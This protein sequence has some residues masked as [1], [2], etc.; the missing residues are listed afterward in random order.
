MTDSTPATSWNGVDPSAMSKEDIAKIL[1]KIA[2]IEDIKDIPLPVVYAC[3]RR[4][5]TLSVTYAKRIDFLPYCTS[6]RDL[7]LVQ[8]IG[9]DFTPLASCGAL[10]S[11]KITYSTI[12]DITPLASC[13]RL[14]HLDLSRGMYAVNDL[15]P[16]VAC[17]DLESL[18]VIYDGKDIGALASCHALKDLN[19]RA[20]NVT[21]LA[22]LA[23]CHALRDLNLSGMSNLEDLGPLSSCTCLQR[24]SLAGCRWVTDITPVPAGRLQRLDLSNTSVD[25]RV[26]SRFPKLTHLTV[27]DCIGVLYLARAIILILRCCSYVKVIG[28]LISCVAL[29]ALCLCWCEKLVDIA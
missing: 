19:L 6:L 11:L 18:D 29:H 22:P 2:R 20:G 7:E 1:G 21:D 23:W 27:G 15:G 24:L 28:P 26:L 9:N 17:T 14:K 13:K 25:L 10:E 4:V 3:Y 12:H 16:L 5:E 8:Y